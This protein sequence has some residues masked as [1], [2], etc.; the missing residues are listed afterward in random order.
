MK[1]SNING[2]CPCGSGKQ[3]SAC[4]GPLHAG[5]DTA[6]TAE[7]LMRARY[8]A[9]VVGD[10]AFLQKSWHSSTRPAQVLEK[11]ADKT[12]WSGLNVI[13]CIAGGENDTD[14]TVEFIARFEV[15]KQAGQLHEVS[16]FRHEDGHW[17][18]VDG[19][20]KKNETIRSD[21]IGRNEPCPCGSGKKY[22]KCC[23]R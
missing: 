5:S 7:A 8:S 13:D 10:E 15:H 4:C 20:S 19:Q 6:K 3:Y 14:G 22:K 11:D 9:F 18:Y 12:H 17:Y 21:K 2:I 16:S 1:F 23:G